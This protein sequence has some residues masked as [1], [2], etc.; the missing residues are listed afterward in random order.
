L[1]EFEHLKPLKAKR[2]VFMV[3]QRIA[4]PR[5]PFLQ[6]LLQWTRQG[7]REEATV[8]GLIR[9]E[10]QDGFIELAVL[11]LSQGIRPAAFQQQ[12][13]ELVEEVDVFRCERERER[14]QVN[15]LCPQSK[16]QVTPTQRLGDA[17][18]TVALIQDD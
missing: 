8:G 10:R 12:L 6:P 13:H 16:L 9:L 5:G 17:P 7:Q 1:L 11:T 4:P 2:I 14:V 18:V 15:A 3:E